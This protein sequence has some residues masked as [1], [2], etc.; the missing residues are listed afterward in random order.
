[1]EDGRNHVGIR[2]VMVDGRNHMRIGAA[3]AG[4]EVRTCTRVHA[5]ATAR[6]GMVAALA[7]LQAVAARI[8]VVVAQAAARTAAEEAEARHQHPPPEHAQSGPDQRLPSGEQ[9]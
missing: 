7:G 2:A 4:T 5:K 6:P 9:A 8:V 3:G 1:M